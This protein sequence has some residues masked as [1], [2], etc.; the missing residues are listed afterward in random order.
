MTLD[1]LY[2]VLCY[3]YEYYVL[4]ESSVPDSEYDRL[5]ASLPEWLREYIGV[6]SS[7]KEDYPEE[8]INRYSNDNSN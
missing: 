1:V 4:N 2:Q 6:G 5:E 7:N 8:I 3:R